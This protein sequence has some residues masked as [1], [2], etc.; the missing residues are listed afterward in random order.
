M[1]QCMGPGCKKKARVKFCS[2]KCKD[3]YH[4]WNNPRGKFAHLHPSNQV[5]K[6]KGQLQDE[7]YEDNEKYY[8]A[9]THP[10][11]TEALGQD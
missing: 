9:M 6:T 11:S 3:R 7:E 4:N 1:A 2:N 10:F 5:Y 8:D